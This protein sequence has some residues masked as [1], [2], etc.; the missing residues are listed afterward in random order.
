MFTKNQIATSDFS[1]LP[2]KYAYKK[3]NLRFKFRISILREA[4]VFTKKQIAVSGF[5]FRFCGRQMCL[6]KTKL[7]FQIS[8]SRGANVFTKNRIA[9]SD[10]EFRFREGQM[11]LQ[12]T[13]LQFYFLFI[14]CRTQA[15]RYRCYNNVNTYSKTTRL[16][17]NGKARG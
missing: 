4:N 10:F 11:C 2:G 17:G 15:E 6:Q 7:Q 13:K 12:K 5:E 16:R 14:R 3:P 1:V 8:V 9:V